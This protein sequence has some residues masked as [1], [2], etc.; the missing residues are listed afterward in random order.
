VVVRILVFLIWLIAMTMG[1]GALRADQPST[2]G[3][4]QWISFYPLSAPWQCHGNCAWALYGGRQLTT[5]LSQV[6]YVQHFLFPHDG[7]DGFVPP[8][9]YKFGDSWFLGGTF[10][11][12]LVEFAKW[13]DIEGEIGVGKRFGSLDQKEIWAALYFR[14]KWFPWNDY[15]NTSIAVSTGVNYASGIATY[16]IAQSGNGQ[17][18]RLLHFFSPEVTFALPSKPDWQFLIRVHHRSGGDKYWGYTPMFKN[19]EGGAQYLVMVSATGFNGS[20]VSLANPQR[21][22]FETIVV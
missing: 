19:V 5:D 15:I 10:S 18:S 3:W 6:V 7:A 8:N 16:E 13:A 14:W 1:S 9:R 4:S 11:N 21:S 22:S 17:G 20:R 2:S 12:V